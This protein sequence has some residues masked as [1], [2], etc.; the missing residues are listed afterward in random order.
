MKKC[1]VSSWNVWRVD[2][3]YYS[4]NVV[5]ILN[6][7][8]IKNIIAL[9]SQHIA[10]IFMNCSSHFM[11]LIYKKACIALCLQHIAKYSS[12][13]LVNLSN[14]QIRSI[15][16]LEN[17][18][19]VFCSCITTI[20]FGSTNCCR[21]ITQQ[22]HWETLPWKMPIPPTCFSMTSISCLCQML[23]KHSVSI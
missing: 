14:Q 5:V 4:K 20:W 16:N 19:F 15:S 13:F 1:H 12:I 2:V 21:C 3:S 23:K 18:Y 9:C 10:K 11:L 7:S 17:A 6:Y 22:I 8:N